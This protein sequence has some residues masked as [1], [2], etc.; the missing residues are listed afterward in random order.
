MLLQPQDIHG[1][2]KLSNAPVQG[3]DRRRAPGCLNAA[4]RQS[5]SELVGMSRNK[6]HETLDPLSSRTSVGHYCRVK[7]AGL[8]DVFFTDIFIRSIY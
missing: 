6:I 5:K 1:K 3:S 4:C 8:D 7:V 2:L